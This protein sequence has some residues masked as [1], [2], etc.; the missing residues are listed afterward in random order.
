MTGSARTA[1]AAASPAS[2]IGADGD[3]DVLP[4]DPSFMEDDAGTGWWEEAT[5]LVE[6]DDDWPD[7]HYGAARLGIP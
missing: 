5:A 2:R 6:T 3:S 7:T 4:P 1:L